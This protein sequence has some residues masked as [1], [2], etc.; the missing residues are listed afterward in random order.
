[1]MVAAQVAPGGTSPGRG[2]ESHT[3][4]QAK[5]STG[6]FHGNTCARVL[7]LTP[8]TKAGIGNGRDHTACD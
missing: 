4:D 7:T 5:A 3:G 2:L 1:M 6:L 8:A